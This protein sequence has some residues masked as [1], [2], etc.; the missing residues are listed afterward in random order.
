MGRITSTHTGLEARW[1]LGAQ[2]Y[3]GI[4]GPYS[5]YREYDQWGNIT[6]R[7]GWGGWLGGGMDQQLTYNAQNQQAGMLYD[8]S[9]NLTNDGEQNYSYDATG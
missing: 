9:G 2:P 4:D 3:S 8:A 1:H 6:R 7:G 5:Q